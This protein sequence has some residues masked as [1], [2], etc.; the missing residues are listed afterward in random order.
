MFSAKLFFKQN[1]PVVVGPRITSPKTVSFVMNQLDSY[2]ITA[3]GIPEIILYDKE[4]ALPYGMYFNASTGLISGVPNIEY[5]GGVPVDVPAVKETSIVV[6][7]W[8]LN[9]VYVYATIKIL[10]YAPLPVFIWNG[11][12][13]SQTWGIFVNEPTSLTLPV[14][15]SPHTFTATNMPPGMSL[16]TATG[17]IS[18]TPTQPGSF[19]IELTATNSTGTSSS[20]LTVIVTAKVPIITS[21]LNLTNVTGGSFSYQIT[22][23]RTP[24]SY[25]ATGLPS[26]L[27]I[28]TATGLITGTV[29]NTAGNISFTITATNSVGTSLENTVNL[30]IV[31]LVDVSSE[32][33]IM[34]TPFSG[35]SAVF[36]PPPEYGITTDGSYSLIKHD[37]VLFPLSAS[38]AKFVRLDTKNNSYVSSY[39]TVLVNR[40]PYITGPVTED[41]APRELIGGLYLTETYGMTSVNYMS[42]TEQ[43]VMMTGSKQPFSFKYSN[44]SEAALSPGVSVGLVRFKREFS[45]NIW[46]YIASATPDGCVTIGSDT[47]ADDNGVKYLGVIVIGAFNKFNPNHCKT[48]AATGT[49]ILLGGGNVDLGYLARIEVTSDLVDSWHDAPPIPWEMIPFES[50][51]I[52]KLAVVEVYLNYTTAAWNSRYSVLTSTN[53]T[54]ILLAGTTNGVICTSSD[55]GSTWS[56]PATQPFGS[57]DEIVEFGAS[58]IKIYAV[59]RNGKIAVSADGGVTWKRLKISTGAG[60]TS[61]NFVKQNTVIDYSKNFLYDPSVT[62]NQGTKTKSSVYIGGSGF[63][64]RGPGDLIAFSNISLPVINS[65]LTV[66]TNV[67]SLTTYQI[68]ATNNPTEYAA[69]GLPTGF[70][71]NEYTGLI[72]GQPTVAGTFTVT[73]T[74]SNPAG[75]ASAS[76]SLNIAQAISGIPVI[77]SVK[78]LTGT[79][80]SQLSYQITATGNPTS[81]SSTTLPSGLTLNSTS[82]LLEG[83]SAV[84]GNYT[85]KISATNNVGIGET[86]LSIS[87][88]SKLIIN[89]NNFPT[90]TSSDTLTAYLGVPF[91]YQITTYNNLATSFEVTHLPPGLSLNATT[92]V[93]SG[94]PASDGYG[95]NSETNTRVITVTLMG[96]DPIY[97]TTRRSTYSLT[98]TVIYLP[99]ITSTLTRLITN[100]NSNNIS[101]Q[102]TASNNPTSFSATGLPAGLSLNTSTGLITGTLSSQG[103]YGGIILG[104]TNDIGTGASKTLTITVLLAPV[105]TSSTAN[106]S[107]VTGTAFN[108]QITASNNP[109]SFAVE[110]LPTGLYLGYTG[111]IQGTPTTAGSATITVKA[112]NAA[113]TGSATISLLIQN[114]PSITSATTFDMV[115]QPIGGTSYTYTIQATGN[116]TTYSAANLPAG[117]SMASPASLGQI[118]GAPYKPG[119]YTVTVYA[120]NSIGTGSANITFTGNLN[121]ALTRPLM[122]NDIVAIK[123]GISA[124]YQPIQI[125]GDAATFYEAIDLPAGLS[126]NSI[127]GQITG[128]PIVSGQHS[129][130]LR[131]WNARGVLESSLIFVIANFTGVNVPV[132]TGALTYSRA[133]DVT[134]NLDLPF[135]NSPTSYISQDVPTGMG[136]NSLYGTLYNSYT[137]A[138][139]SSRV[140]VAAVNAGGLAKTHITINW[141]PEATA[142]VITTT[143]Y[144]SATTTGRPFSYNITATGKNIIY[145]SQNLPSGLSLNTSTGV[146]SGTIQGLGEYLVRLTATNAAGVSSDTIRIY[147]AD[148]VS[149]K[150]KAVVSKDGYKIAVL[151]ADG[152]VDEY[153]RT[154]DNFNWTY[155]N[156][157]WQYT[158]SFLVDIAVGDVITLGLTSTGSV[159]AWYNFTTYWDSKD[160]PGRLN[161]VISALISGGVTKIAVG[162][163]GYCLALKTDG[164]LV[165]WIV[166]GAYFT[167]NSEQ[168]LDKM[169]YGGTFKDI[170]VANGLAAAVTTSGAVI[171]W[172]ESAA[173]Y[174][175]DGQPVPPGAQSGVKSISAGMVGYLAIKEDG[176]AVQWTSWDGNGQSNNAPDA[177]PAGIGIKYIAGAASNASFLLMDTSYKGNY[178]SGT[179]YYP[180]DIVFWYSPLATTNYRVR[181]NVGGSAPYDGGAIPDANWGSAFGPSGIRR[182]FI[183]RREPTPPYN[184]HKVGD[185]DELD[186]PDTLKHVTSISAGVV[187]YLAIYDGGKVMAW[188]SGKTNLP[189]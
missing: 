66:N 145:G 61:L 158:Q 119:V 148:S 37:K 3:T 115:A 155:Y 126:I 173:G 41:L 112:N 42:T 113:G 123:S 104:A 16:D 14:L 85:I 4:G 23:T 189:F 49:H 27:S 72:H 40:Q 79:E 59:T 116:P 185:W 12:L 96:I 81:Y 15:Y 38:G 65:S 28:N 140:L 134:G 114:P 186:P 13:T 33:E 120:T 63:L 20:T 174:W 47:Y 157:S 32:W 2:Q 39:A 78:N 160:I 152:F 99:V 92:G 100:T 102:I 144:K 138:A 109:N 182:T 142:P 89:P 159:V 22:A 67:N 141:T 44:Q 176:T 172:N 177:Y 29:P 24:T 184:I 139:S 175:V 129:A 68:T 36:G 98:I 124:N 83:T 162:T 6:Y 90:L 53:K 80:G 11:D 73:I 121:M 54:A 74:A 122:Q 71:I 149:S 87:L 7:V 30:A 93:I 77:T 86:W 181:L 161:Y 19:L 154:Y 143:P 111:N 35:T 163:Q 164:T 82:G 50:G 101:Y 166:P 128:I 55:N 10:V 1:V 188:G 165:G 132:F 9:G 34:D 171:T 117:M 45:G 169:P 76:L 187:I 106:L 75:T 131:A 56:Y 70:I 180:K 91:T 69:S 62:A 43:P 94:T 95:I 105:I 52:S 17:L 107:L 25:A 147:V 51:V 179:T 153:R 168:L 151:R 5:V 58:S 57:G 97:G 60:A 146:I 46:R 21:L 103:T 48:I 31:Q 183:F 118:I 64:A 84:S 108:Y 150:V 133:V 130:T 178:S 18:G 156:V 136:Y 125:S 88:A 127:T 8:G 135:S 167:N 110:G 137:G 170:S 26:G